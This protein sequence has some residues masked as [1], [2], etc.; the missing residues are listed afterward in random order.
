MVALGTK[1]RKQASEASEVASNAM[2]KMM[3]AAGSA[4]VAAEP[5]PPAAGPAGPHEI[6]AQ[7]EVR[8]TPKIK[9]RCMFECGPSRPLEELFRSNPRASP[10][11]HPCYNAMRALKAVASKTEGQKAAWLGLQE[12][13]PEQWKAR[14]RAC[15]ISDLT[16]SAFGAP[17]LATV[18]QR[19][20][21]IHT[22][23]T[24]LT[25]TVGVE[26]TGGVTWMKKSEFIRHQ[27][28]NDEATVEDAEA[29]WA[30]KASEPGV[31]NM[32]GDE[33]RVP[34]MKMPETVV[35]RK[36]EFS[37]TVT[38]S[39]SL[40]S[41]GQANDAV[42]QLSGVG[43]GMAALSGPMFGDMTNVLRPG[44]AV[45]SNTGQVLPL[46]PLQAPPTQLVVPKDAFDGPVPK[47]KRTLGATLSCPDD[48][49]DEGPVKKRRVGGSA[50]SGVT[51]DLLKF[52]QTGL[53]MCAKL[54]DMFG[55]Q[56][57]NIAKQLEASTRISGNQLSDD[58]QGTV[59]AYMASLARVKELERGVKKWTQDNA[60]AS[61]DELSGIADSLEAGHKLLTLAHEDDKARREKDRKEAAKV[62]NEANKQRAK[63]TSAY[64]G[65][66]PDAL[67]RFLF[68]K[69][70]LVAKGTSGPVGGEAASRAAGGAGAATDKLVDRW[71]VVTVDESAFDQD[72]PAFFPAPCSPAEEEKACVGQQIR[73]LVKHIGQ[74]RVNA[75]EA[76]CV[77]SLQTA[78]GGSTGQATKRL[79]PKGQHQ[80]SLELMEWVP[81]HWRA[82]KHMP[83]A[84]RSWGSP[85]LMVSTIGECRLGHDNW[86]LSGIGQFLTGVSGQHTVVAW[87]GNSVTALGCS[88]QDMYM[89]LFKEMTPKTFA[90][91][92]EQHLRFVCM[93]QK[94]SVW[95]P[96]GWYA[97]LLCRPGDVTTGSVMS[98]P[99][100]AQGLAS[101]CLWWPQVSQH[102]Q[103]VVA[104]YINVG[105]PKFWRERGQAASEWLIVVVNSASHNEPP[106]L[107]DGIPE[108]VA[109]K[110]DE[111]GGQ[112]Q[113]LD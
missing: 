93:P 113:D 85:K 112:K 96:Y 66:A 9:A 88:I 55:K 30:S 48:E 35:Y 5:A 23:L 2:H 34:V 39:A 104:G 51:G 61:V 10:M 47:A 36:R 100:V 14:V 57:K 41:Q 79:E 3:P 103:G 98:Q 71:P 70:G 99:Y 31:M 74:A 68:D 94:A 16:E 13:D 91:W 54:W 95:V 53:D 11:C 86:A 50:L 78:G 69:G 7:Q 37:K 72:R 58:V 76:E 46:A 97:A 52:R 38:S 87:P 62:R 29:I 42:R 105:K 80:D 25:Q 84:L 92:A 28:S 4:L 111:Q 12:K 22:T 44:V 83:E 17:G 40:E 89:F 81:E 90:E 24:S 102:L 19:R 45:G 8:D 59:Q 32:P 108:T 77:R 26:E 106:A 6:V 20:S 101:R 82:A 18:G 65:S 73:D 43:T 15:R 110:E 109:D 27:V 63:L 33:V 107:Q 67:V 60:E 75:A 21:L 56:G 64:K 49:L 1:G